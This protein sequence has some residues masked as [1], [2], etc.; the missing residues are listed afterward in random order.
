MTSFYNV[1]GP[2]NRSNAYGS[3][4]LARARTIYPFFSFP[5]LSCRLARRHF[6]RSLSRM[7]VA[8]PPLP[9]SS[10]A[11]QEYSASEVAELL[12]PATVPDGLDGKVLHTAFHDSGCRKTKADCFIILKFALKPAEVDTVYGI[13]NSLLTQQHAWGSRSS[14]LFTYLFPIASPAV[15]FHMRIFLSSSF[16]PHSCVMNCA[17]SFRAHL[18]VERSFFVPFGPRPNFAV[19]SRAERALYYFLPTSFLTC[20]LQFPVDFTC[21]HC[22]ECCFSRVLLF[23]SGILALPVLSSSVH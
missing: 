22:L 8:P 17:S 18:P 23:L 10:K 1:A 6:S 12:K 5:A 7:A 3:Y 11:L 13:V 21:S 9:V 15:S 2:K 20:C 16:S 14:A 19:S 4:R